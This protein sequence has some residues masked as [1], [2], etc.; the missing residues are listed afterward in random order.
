[1]VGGARDHEVARFQIAVDYTIG[2]LVMH[3]SQASSGVHS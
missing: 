3:V 1:V 2:S